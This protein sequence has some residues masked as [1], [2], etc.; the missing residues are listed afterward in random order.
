[1][2]TEKKT[3]WLRCREP[4]G[5]KHAAIPTCLRCVEHL[6]PMDLQHY[7][8]IYAV[9]S[10]LYYGYDESFFSDPAYDG[11][12]SALLDMKAW[13]KIPWIEKGMLKAGSGYD[14]KNFPREL[15]EAAEEWL[16]S[17]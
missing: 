1:M 5:C 9:A 13:K 8:E 14:L 7:A 4:G 11:I 2:E 12:C 17:K 3:R 16:S 6:R 15:H 10:I